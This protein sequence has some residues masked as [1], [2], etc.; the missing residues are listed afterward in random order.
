MSMALCRSLAYQRNPLSARKSGGHG[1]DEHF[2]R[3][4]AFVP[5]EPRNLK[6]KRKEKYESNSVQKNTN[7]ATAHRTGANRRRRV[8]SRARA[9]NAVYR[10]R[11]NGDPLLLQLRRAQYPFQDGH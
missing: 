9:R 3:A 2:N 7:P 6:T 1:P 5:S 10:R 8:N 11:D 4:F